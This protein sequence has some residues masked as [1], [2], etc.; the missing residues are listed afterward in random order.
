MIG[1][2]GLSTRVAR[3]ER[4][5]G[6]VVRAS[7]AEEAR[8]EERAGFLRSERERRLQKMVSG[9]PMPWLG[10]TIEQQAIFLAVHGMNLDGTAR[11]PLTEAGPLHFE[12]MV[13][14]LLYRRIEMAYMP[15]A[16]VDTYLAHPGRAWD[17]GVCTMCCL[18]QPWR[19]HEPGDEVGY[20][21]GEL[22]SSACQFCGQS[23]GY[24]RGSHRGQGWW[25]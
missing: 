24:L 10:W 16:V 15:P 11:A 22:V 9:G 18:V 17:D 21:T 19:F 1:K 6:A 7:A 8:E 20:P 12:A 23:S 13:A 3:L 2:N 14:S 5:Q 4:S 25:S